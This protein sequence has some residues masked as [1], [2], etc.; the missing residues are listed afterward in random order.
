MSAYSLWNGAQTD[1][2]GDALISGRGDENEQQWFFGFCIS[3]SYWM[4]LR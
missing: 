3:P 2:G 4:A 1:S